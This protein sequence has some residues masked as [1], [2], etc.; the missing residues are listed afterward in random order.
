MTRNVGG[1]KKD[2]YK[3]VFTLKADETTYESP[4][5]V[6]PLPVSAVLS[7]QEPPQET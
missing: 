6:A 3:N 5:M 4:L 2:K 1:Q 7:G